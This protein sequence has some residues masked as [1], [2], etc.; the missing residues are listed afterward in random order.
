MKIRRMIRVPDNATLVL[1][2]LVRDG[3]KDPNAYL[4]SLEVE[5]S[6]VNTQTVVRWHRI[7]HDATL[8]KPDTEKLIDKLILLL[9]D[10]ACTR[11]ERDEAV[12]AVTKTGSTQAFAALQEK[13][14]RL[15]TTSATTGEVG[16]L[17]LYF[18]AEHLL[19]YPQ[20]LCKF[21]LKTNPNVHAHGADGVH[22]SVDPVTNHL[23]LHWGEAKLYQNLGAAVEDCFS[24]LSEL[25]LEPTG[26]K[27][28]KRRDVEL[29]RDY[30]DLS[31]P[32]L[33][34][35]FRSYLDPDNVLSKKVCYCGLALIGFDLADYN[36][37]TNEVAKKEVASISAR[38][39]DW[40]A[41]IK[42][43]LE[44]H[45]LVGITIDVFCIPFPSVQAFRDAFLKRLG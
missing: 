31:E 26:A 21:P 34:M 13:A 20:V 33:E 16:E 27:K 8:G 4:D 11:K 18:L 7:G 39:Q 10:F 40:T 35:A 9:I 15:F 1:A 14:R 25:I 32:G 5:T 30:I 29:L 22:A 28:T 36:A 41:K 45:E 23:R 2:H 42:A 6:V 24:S 37:L 44:K 38:V 12:L 19:K 17:M 43:S 3:G